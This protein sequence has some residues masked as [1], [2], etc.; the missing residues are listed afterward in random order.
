MLTALNWNCGLFEIFGWN[1][2]VLAKNEC[3][4]ELDPMFQGAFN[5]N[6]KRTGT[7]NHHMITLFLNTKG[8]KRIFF[9]YETNQPILKFF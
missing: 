1:R 6:T 2:V 4:L 5:K 9:C 3:L 7:N 8:L